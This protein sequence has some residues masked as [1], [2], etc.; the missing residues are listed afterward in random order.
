MSRQSLSDLRSLAF[1]R[2]ALTSQQGVYVESRANGTV[3][4]VAARVAGYADPD[5]ASAELEAD[6]TV[7][8]AIEAASRVKQRQQAITREDVISGFLD[9]VALATTATEVVAAWREIGK[10]NGLYEPQKVEITKTLKDLTR[11]KDEEL[12]RLAPLDGDFRVLDFTEEGD[13]DVGPEA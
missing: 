4:V 2:E 8:M 7:R 10:I 6:T 3:P 13:A 9:A 1:L 5:A 11:L 12:V